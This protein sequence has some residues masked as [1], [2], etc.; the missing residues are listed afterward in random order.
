VFLGRGT[1]NGLRDTTDRAL[2]SSLTGVSRSRL[3]QFANLVATPNV[4]P[5]GTAIFF[6]IGPFL[7]F[8]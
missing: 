5:D 8:A 7:P 6:I 2:G 1:Q 3:S 4:L